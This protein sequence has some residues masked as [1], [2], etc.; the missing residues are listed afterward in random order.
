MLM[1]EH[2][3]GFDEGRWRDYQAACAA[4]SKGGALLVPGIEYSDPANLVHVAV[5]G[6]LPFLGEGRAIDELLADVASKGGAAML[7]HPG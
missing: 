1:T 6:D 3:R 2:D 7:A 5:W 4:A